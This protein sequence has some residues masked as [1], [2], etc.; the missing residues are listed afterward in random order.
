MCLIQNNKLLIWLF[1]VCT[2][3]SK[4]IHTIYLSQ[5]EYD[6]SIISVLV[7]L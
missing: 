1:D 3:C 5:K 2:F 4:F 6:F 7:I